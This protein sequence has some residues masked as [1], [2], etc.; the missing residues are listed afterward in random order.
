M[1]FWNPKQFQI[2]PNMEGNSLFAG[3]GFQL[4]VVFN[5]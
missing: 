3:K 2:Y 1:G 4:M 5:Y